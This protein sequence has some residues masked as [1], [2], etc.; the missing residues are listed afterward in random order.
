[1]MQQAIEDPRHEIPVE[2]V[3]GWM[4]DVQ[5]ERPLTDALEM[6]V[7]HYSLW[8]DGVHLFNAPAGFNA[9]GRTLHRY[10]Q[11]ESGSAATDTFWDSAWFK[12]YIVEPAKADRPGPAAPSKRVGKLRLI[13]GDARTALG[14][15][16][17]DYFDGAV[18][19]PPYYNARDYSQWEN[20]YCYLHDMYAIAL[21]CYRVLKPGAVYL[22]NIFDTFDNERSIVFSAMGDKRLALSSTTIDLFRRAGF[23][24]AGSVSWD[25]GDIE[26]KRGFNAGN[27][28]PHYQSPFNCW[29]HVLIFRKPGDRRGAEIPLPSVLSAK[30]VFKMHNGSNTYGHT[31][32]FPMAV[33]ELLLPLL[34]NG[35]RVLDPFGGSAT[36]A[37]ALAS[38]AEE[39]VCVELH[40]E[41]CELAVRLYAEE[42]DAPNDEAQSMPRSQ[43]DLFP[44]R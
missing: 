39:T 9:E 35:A 4:R 1:M 23:E 14:Q 6:L 16:P 40:E 7:K 2:S 5:P 26:G 20:I 43:L 30:P 32:P 19:S 12:R 44:Q 15:I 3:R 29:E 27:F 24:V 11:L 18:T 37:R 28:S 21:E 8:G 34:P 41:Y 17:S 13:Q 22:Y 42:D 10:S 38:V 33:P 25:K 36:T 31:A